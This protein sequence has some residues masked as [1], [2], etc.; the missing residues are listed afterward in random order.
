MTSTDESIQIPSKA[1]SEEKD[2]RGPVRA[3][4]QG[5]NLL[6]TDE[7]MEDAGKPSAAFVGPP[8]SVALIEAGAT[9]AAKWWAAGLGALVI[10]LWGS[11]AA[12]YSGEPDDVKVALVAGAGLATSALI[13]AIGYLIA[14]DVR[15][16][17]AASVSLIEARARLATEMINAAEVV[18][19]PTPA[20][21]PVEV[22][23]LPK[24]IRVKNR[25]A[26]DADGWL[27]VAME[28]H[29]DGNRY[30]LVKGSSEATEPASALD[31][32]P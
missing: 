25:A 8:Q 21:P 23:A 26:A 4:L 9:A 31:F 14:S 28:R 32:N 24:Q 15:G 20:A 6:G 16:R 5:L 18:Y 29:T 27:A 2:L 17:A 10:P 7:E 1:V 22:V 30:I 19:Q 11:V 13:I 12:W 3:L